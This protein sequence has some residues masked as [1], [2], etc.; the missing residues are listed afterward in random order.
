MVKERFKRAVAIMRSC[1]KKTD[2]K[3][4][5]R[6]TDQSQEGTGKARQNSDTSKDKC[7]EAI[8]N[9]LK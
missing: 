8:R 7:R 6:H 4:R 3:W 9:P 2:Q 1:E 5:Q